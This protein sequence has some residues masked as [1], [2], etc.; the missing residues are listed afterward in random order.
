MSTELEKTKINELISSAEM[1]ISRIE[2][3]VVT[4]QESAD[5]IREHIWCMLTF[6]ETFS[7]EWRIVDRWKNENG[8]NMHPVYKTGVYAG[9]KEKEKVV[10][11]LQF[12]KTF[13]PQELNLT[14]KNEHHFSVAQGYQAKQFI[15][16]IFR[17]AGKKIVVIDEHLDDQFFHYVD[18]IPDAIQ[19]NV[20]T[21]DKKQIFWNLYN[22]LKKNRSSID[23]RI[24]NI[25]H[26]RYIIIDDSIIYSTDASLNTIGKKDFMIHKME[27]ADEVTKVKKEIEKYWNDA[28]IK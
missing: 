11:L 17:L 18:I 24:N 6:F 22:E 2:K 19:I 20:I 23:A 7:D 27:N 21:G 3:G 26:C 16:S 28:Q 12:L 8:F 5:F 4:G 10:K 14:S 9:D 25:S 15:C 1:M 13:L